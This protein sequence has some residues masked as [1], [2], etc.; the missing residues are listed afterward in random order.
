VM[1]RGGADPALA[2]VAIPLV[3]MA[4]YLLAIVAAMEQMGFNVGS[5][6]AG[7][8]VAG[9]AIG[10]AAQE[11]LGSIFAGFVLLWDRPFRLGDAVTISGTYG[12]VTEIGLRSTRLRTLEHREVTIPNKQVVQEQI[13]NHTR[14]PKVRLNVPVG[15]AY[16]ADLDRARAALLAAV[17]S[18]PAVALE[19]AP[20]VVVVALGEFA[21]QVELR[22][23]VGDQNA[24]GASL[25]HLIEAGKRALDEAGIEFPLPLRA[26]RLVGL[27]PDAP[28]R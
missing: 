15:V 17:A 11:T 4:F 8:G 27:P 23:W 21:V 3:R 16:G 13:V 25:F 28:E 20:Q 14:Y 6:L 19:P 18:N 7:V 26:V 5:L 24:P 12:T 10:L 9:L 2:N 1:T 22:V